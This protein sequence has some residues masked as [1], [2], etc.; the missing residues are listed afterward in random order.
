MEN[1]TQAAL[2]AMRKNPDNYKLGLFYFNP[3]DPR[4]ILPKMYKWMGYTI[5]FAKP[6]SYLIVL[7]IVAL[8]YFIN[9]KLKQ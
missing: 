8:I 1:N 9:L 3:E 4:V 7:I 5:N 6:L 2:D